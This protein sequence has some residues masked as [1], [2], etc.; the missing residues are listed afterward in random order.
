VRL[1]G[2]GD[3]ILPVDKPAGPTSHDVVALA[4]RGL[5]TR[6]I[7]HT[8]TLDPFA[9]GLLLLL[10]NRATRLAEYLQGHP[11]EYVAVARLGEETTTLDV[12]GEVTVR[13]DAWKGLAEARIREA[14]AEMAGEQEQVP[15]AYSA[16]KVGGEA[17]YAR[18]RRG[19]AVR[20]RPVPI[21]VDEIEL[22]H[23]ELPHVRFRVRASTGTYIRALARDLGRRLGVG[24]HLREL[25][26][27][28]IGPFQ[29]EEALMPEELGDAAAVERA[30]VPPLA[31]LAHLPAVEVSAGDAVRLASGQSV[32][33]PGPLEG[34][35]SV[36]VSVGGDL[37]AVAD[38]EGTRLRPRKVFPR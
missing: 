12:E 26:R 38:V 10:V 1:P 34:A 20:L 30:W 31:A 24:A 16:K 36:A 32:L 14:L 8:G 2:T 19:E 18:A 5:E 22:I 35:G 21:T 9:S 33:R 17:S 13:S 25:R 23:L 7:G 29:V 11:K 4:R 37:L 6:R 15:P 3:G 27:T 28:G